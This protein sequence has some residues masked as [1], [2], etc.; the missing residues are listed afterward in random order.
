QPF[1]P[2]GREAAV[3]LL[4]DDR[5]EPARDLDGAVARAVVDDDRLVAADALE[6]AL[7]VLGRVV[8][9]HYN[10]YFTH[11]ILPSEAKGQARHRGKCAAFSAG[12]QPWRGEGRAIPRRLSQARISA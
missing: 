6:A 9:N 2:A 3:L 4:D 10:G 1:V 12:G 11:P 5:A 8:R 7:E